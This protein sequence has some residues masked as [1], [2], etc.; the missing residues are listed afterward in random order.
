[1][2]VTVTCPECD[3]RL[4]APPT[5]V[6]KKIRCPACETVFLCQADEEVP[7][8]VKPLR[9]REHG[10]PEDSADS[11]DSRSDDQGESPPARRRPK[12]RPIKKRSFAGLWIGCAVLGGFVALAA[13]GGAAVL[14]YMLGRNASIPD[15]DWV[16][17]ST[18]DGACSVLMPGAPVLDNTALKNAPGNKYLLVRKQ[19]D[20]FFAVAYVDLPALGVAPGLL[21]LASDGE[22]DALQQKVGGTVIHDQDVN[23]LGYTGRE[24][25]IRAAPPHRGVLME[26]LFMVP[27]GLTTRLYIVGTGGS[28]IEPGTG[29]AAKFFDSLAI[30]AAPT[31]PLPVPFNPPPGQINPKPKK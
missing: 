28:I 29:A 22:R 12:R 31:D 5:S 30:K 1:M 20:V 8:E 26:R 9:E 18:P 2:A 19:E 14:L 27:R 10:D 4:V 11:A 15:G 3:R 16:Q 7:V 24:F 17:F 13:V 23:V 25:Q 6:G 21:K